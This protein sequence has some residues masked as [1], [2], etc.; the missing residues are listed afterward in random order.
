D[1]FGVTFDIRKEILLI[2]SIQRKRLP[3]VAIQLLL[4]QPLFNFLSKLKNFIINLQLPLRPMMQ[5]YHLLR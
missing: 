4:G 2:F 5:T 3:K 1:I